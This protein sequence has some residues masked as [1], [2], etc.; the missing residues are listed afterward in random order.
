M[1][2]IKHLYVSGGLGASI[3]VW[4]AAGINIF[5]TDLI[6]KFESVG[7][8]SLLGDIAYIQEPDQETLTA[9]KE[10][11]QIVY[12]AGNPEFEELFLEN[13]RL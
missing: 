13:L 6:K 1:D 3:G 2:D 8:S 7:N 5:P 4:S 11:S 10:N 12:M 9:I